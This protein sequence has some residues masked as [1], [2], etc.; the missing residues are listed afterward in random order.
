MSLHARHNIVWTNRF[1][2][3][4]FVFGEV[5]KPLCVGA[6]FVLSLAAL[7]TK[8]NFLNYNLWF[9]SFLRA[10]KVTHNCHLLHV[11][12]T[13]CVLMWMYIRYTHLSTTAELGD[14]D[15]AMH[16]TMTNII[17]MKRNEGIKCT[18][19]NNSRARLITHSAKHTMERERAVSNASPYIVKHYNFIVQFHWFQHT[20]LS[21]SF[22]VCASLRLCSV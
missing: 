8:S 12:T 7:E 17:K 18:H 14:V 20:Q 19:K 5:Q 6:L 15:D 1:Q 10:Q 13:N 9:V 16:K 4:Q 22:R 2:F 11:P 3:I 21:C